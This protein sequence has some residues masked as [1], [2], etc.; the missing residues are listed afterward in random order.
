M[1]SLWTCEELQAKLKGRSIP[2][3]VIKKI[4]DFNG[5]EFKTIS[6]RDMC[7]QL[8]IDYKNAAKIHSVITEEAEKEKREDRL[9]FLK[10]KKAI[11]RAEHLRTWAEKKA[12]ERA[13]QM[14]ILQEEKASELQSASRNCV[15]FC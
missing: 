7:E 8:E 9:R 15:Q 11:E 14:R 13:E 1:I 10:E 5:A 6:L 4:A 3:D 12:S 2:D